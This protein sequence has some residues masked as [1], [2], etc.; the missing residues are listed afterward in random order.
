MRKPV[1]IADFEV[2]LEQYVDG[3]LIGVL[4]RYDNFK[5]LYPPRCGTKFPPVTNMFARYQKR[6]YIAQAKM[7]GINN[8]IFVDP[9]RKIQAWNRSG[10]P[11]TKFSFNDKNSEVLR[12]IP[13]NKWWVFNAELLHHSGMKEINFFHDVLV[14]DGKVLTGMTYSDRYNLLWDTIVGDLSII[15]DTP[16]FEDTDDHYTIDRY[17]WIARS[18]A[19]LEKA[20][21]TFDGPLHEG[22]VVKDPASKLSLQDLV[23]R[24]VPWMAKARRSDRSKNVTF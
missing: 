24:D 16:E 1:L 10:T 14:A 9:D 15:P 4:M 8:V 11:I 6:G 7:N 22:I 12:N 17:N 5:Y 20:Y 2:D 3:I 19:K 18:W 13:G 21:K 23:G